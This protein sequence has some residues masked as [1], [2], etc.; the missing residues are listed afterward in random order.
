MIC[1][2]DAQ[3]QPHDPMPRVCPTGRVMYRGHS[4]QIDIDSP[5]VRAEIDARIDRFIDSLPETNF[6]EIWDD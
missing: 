4:L 3:L 6:V 2:C 5:E 1:T